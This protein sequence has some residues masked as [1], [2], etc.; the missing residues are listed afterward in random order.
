M[1][2]LLVLGCSYSDYMAGGLTDVYGSILART[3]GWEYIHEGAGGGSNHRIWRKLYEHV[4]RSVT[5]EDVIVIQYTT[6]ER[7]E[8]W[9]ARPPMASYMT[10]VSRGLTATVDESFDGGTVLR[11]KYGAGG[12][13][14]T[15]TDRRFFDQ[16]ERN[17]VSVAWAQHQ[18]MWTH[19]LLQARLRDLGQRVIFL[20]NRHCPQVDLESPLDAWAFTEPWDL[21]QQPEYR[22]QPEDTAHMN[23]RG[24]H[25][26]AGLLADHVRSL[27]WA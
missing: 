20:H 1:R 14:N 10:P 13:Q 26:L 21:L 25:H 19:W 5:P 22:Y 15:L 9:T 12:W 4:H 27:G 3:L 11:Y 2:R 7:T 6:Q 24:H 18:F 16:Y 8:F 17:H 23:L